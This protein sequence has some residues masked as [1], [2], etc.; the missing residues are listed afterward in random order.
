MPWLR[1]FLANTRSSISTLVLIEDVHSTG[2]H[3]R[4]RGGLAQR[5]GRGAHGARR[6]I[7][8]RTWQ[9]ALVAALENWPKVT[10]RAVRSTPHPP[11]RWRHLHLSKP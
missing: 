1:E 8:V 11:S 3:P 6:T 10:Q 2:T 7:G 9:G 5:P 4:H